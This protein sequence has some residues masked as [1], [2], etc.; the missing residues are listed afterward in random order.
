MY[1]DFVFN[2]KIFFGRFPGSPLRSGGAIPFYTAI[3]S[4]RENIY[5]KLSKIPIFNV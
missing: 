1:I 5:D 2:F 4:G 3:I